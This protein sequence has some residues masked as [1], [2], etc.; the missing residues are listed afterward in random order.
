MRDATGADPQD[1]L[2]DGHPGPVLRLRQGVH[3]QLLGEPA[4]LRGRGPGD[5]GARRAWLLQAQAVRAHLPAPSPL[6]HHRGLRGDSDAP[7]RRVHVRLHAPARA[8]GRGRGLMDERQLADALRDALGVATIESLT[9]LS[10]GASRETW[11]FEAVATDGA[12]T[13]L[14]LRRDPPGRPSEPGAMSRE[15]RVIGQARAA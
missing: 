12:R 14:V 3:V 2:A 4:L 7:G 11:S 6:P 15:A 9:R 1:R 5:A 8:Q 10:G 13:G